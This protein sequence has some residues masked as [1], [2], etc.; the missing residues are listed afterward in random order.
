M[1][2]M[3]SGEMSLTFKV[4]SHARAATCSDTLMVLGTAVS[5]STVDVLLG[6]MKADIMLYTAFNE[7]HDTF[8]TS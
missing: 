7:L 5:S 4:C 2:E 3:C 1:V 8:N 6:S